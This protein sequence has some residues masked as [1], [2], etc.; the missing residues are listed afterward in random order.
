MNNTITIIDY[1]TGNL[2]SIIRK[3]KMLDRIPVVTSQADEILK[4]D[5]I[6]LPG[7][8]HFGK[9]MNQL[10]KLD[11]IAVLNE[12]I[13][14]QKKPVLGICLG[15]QLMADYSEEGNVKGLG[16]ISGTVK[17]IKVENSTEF[18]I[19]HIGWNQLKM[20]KESLLV[21]EINDL[22]EFYFVHGYH[23]DC[24]NKNDILS[25]TDYESKFVSAIEKNN[26]YGVQFHPEKSH[27]IGMQMMKNFLTL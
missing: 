8:G 23:F 1:N 27:E 9:A 20:Q 18:K 24:Q 13:I 19:P 5:K 15:M 4:A 11:L 7:V 26:I 25:Y 14:V 17:K 6:I 22:D 21:R 2:Q 3:I 16:W 10:E 12:A